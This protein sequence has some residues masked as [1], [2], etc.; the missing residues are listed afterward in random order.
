MKELTKAETTKLADAIMV[1]HKHFGGH[2]WKIELGATSYFNPDDF[3]PFKPILVN[4]DQCAVFD[5]DTAQDKQA[6]GG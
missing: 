5:I 6:L 1:L 3:K 4:G 2:E